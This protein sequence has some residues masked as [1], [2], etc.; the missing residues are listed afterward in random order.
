MDEQK[1]VS[2]SYLPTT[3]VTHYSLNH[4][5]ITSSPPFFQVFTISNPNGSSIFAHCFLLLSIP[6][7]NIMQISIRTGIGGAPMSG[8]TLSE[9]RILECPGCIAD[10]VLE[11]ILRQTS[12]DQSWNTRE[13]WYARAP[14]GKRYG[15]PG[16]AK[17]GYWGIRRLRSGGLSYPLPAEG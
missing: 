13:K 12:S 2:C 11:R 1:E 10:T 14:V 17:L 16:R 3:V 5:S 9:I 4:A 7:I 8:R 15:K 6:P